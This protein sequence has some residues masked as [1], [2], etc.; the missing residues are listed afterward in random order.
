VKG[1]EVISLSNLTGGVTL[2]SQTGIGF[3]HTTTI[4]DNLYGGTSRINHQH[5]DGMGSGVDSIL[6]QFLDD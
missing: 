1:E 5:V 3:R 6:H 4:V 2:E